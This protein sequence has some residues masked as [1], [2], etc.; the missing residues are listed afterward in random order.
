MSLRKIYLKALISEFVAVLPS[1]DCF[2]IY[3]ANEVSYVISVNAISIVSNLL[4]LAFFNFH[5]PV[6]RV[7]FMGN[8][9]IRFIRALFL[10][11]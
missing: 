6:P 5:R 2:F 7:I 3:D 4:N 9:S 10:A 1:L 11:K 8:L